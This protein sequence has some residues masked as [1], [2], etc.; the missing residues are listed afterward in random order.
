MGLG[1]WMFSWLTQSATAGS[2]VTPT[3]SDFVALGT[4]A[5][6]LPEAYDTTRAD[7]SFVKGTVA[8]CLDARAQERGVLRFRVLEDGRETHLS[9][10]IQRVLST[11][12]PVQSR[13]DFVECLS[14]FHDAC[15]NGAIYFVAGDAGWPAEMWVIPTFYLVP[16]FERAED[17]VPSA[18]RWADGRVI[19]D[20]DSLC[21]IRNNS[22]KTAP[23]TGR[24]F[25]NDQVDSAILYDC[26]QRAQLNWFQTGGAPNVAMQLAKGSTMDPTQIAQAQ[27]LWAKRYNPMNGSTSLG[28][29]PDG[30]T[31]VNFGAREIDYNVSKDE[32][33]DSIREG[34]Q[35]PKIILGDTDNVNHN[36]GQTA[37]AMFE[38]LVVLRWG[39]KVADSL[40]SYFRQRWSA[41]LSV[42]L[43]PA[44]TAGFTQ[45]P[46]TN[47][48]ID[49]P[50]TADF[51]ASIREV[52]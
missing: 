48:V 34:F 24:G 47:G 19:A 33:R 51:P 36:N 1:K 50:R 49:L 17:P 23:Y 9:K 35:V 29:I 26:I 20:V 46:S 21:I 3:G 37:L 18:Y 15:G 2:S 41:K 43:D 45:L 30:G 5:A 16:L 14:Q 40:E 11:P 28:V 6:T 27:A 22:L 52:D 38:R 8:A 44:V 12:N 7:V 39:Q 4:K 31:I 10:Q 32:I 13:T 42:Q 25:L